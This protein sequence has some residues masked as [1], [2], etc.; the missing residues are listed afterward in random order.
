MNSVTRGTHSGHA[1]PYSNDNYSNIFLVSPS[2]QSRSDVLI[3]HRAWNQERH[4]RMT[5]FI[6]A[7]TGHVDIGKLCTTLR[8]HTATKPSA[9]YL[10]N[11]FWP[12]YM[13]LSELLRNN[14]LQIMYTSRL[15]NIHRLNRSWPALCMGV[16]SFTRLLLQCTAPTQSSIPIR[17]CWAR[18]P[19]LHPYSL[20]ALPY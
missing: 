18:L 4:Q 11:Q 6:D 9:H 7:T 17:Q 15:L 20:R 5:S 14:A 12:H 13:L 16:I 19:P 10:W 1:I 3:T 2:T 8:K